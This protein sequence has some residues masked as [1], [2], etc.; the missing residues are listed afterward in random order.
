[1]GVEPLLNIRDGILVERLVKTMRYVADMRRCKHVV[2]RPEGVRRR[3]RLNVEYVDRRAGDLLVLQHADQCL[4]FDNRPTRRIESTR[5]LASFSPAPRPL[6]GRAYG[7][8]TPDGSSGCRLA[9]TAGPWKPGGRPQLR[10]PRASCSGSG[11]QIHSKA[12]PTRATCDPIRPSPRTP[13]SFHGDPCPLFAASRR[14][15][16]SCSPSRFCRA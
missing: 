10:R 9:R 8:S 15:G 7:C 1:M 2:Q 6:P 16:R 3:Q 13:R 14:I 11:N 4:F 12:L 5:P